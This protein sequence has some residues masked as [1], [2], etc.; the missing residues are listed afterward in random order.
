MELQLAEHFS[1]PVPA[2]SFVCLTFE[3]RAKYKMEKRL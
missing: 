1:D 2:L 3:H